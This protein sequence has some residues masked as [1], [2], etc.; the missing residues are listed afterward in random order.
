MLVDLLS[1]SLSQEIPKLT[2]DSSSCPIVACNVPR[3]D[4]S[5]SL[6]V[7]TVVLVNMTF[8]YASG[9]GKVSELFVQDALAL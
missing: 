2:L 7:S 8:L 5:L 9:Y 4:F 1:P 3:R 6:R